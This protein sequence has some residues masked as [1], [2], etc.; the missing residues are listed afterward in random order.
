M[1][2]AMTYEELEA[3]VN[4]LQNQLKEEKEGRNF[5]YEKY[6]EMEEKYNSM[7]ASLQALLSL[8][9]K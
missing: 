1:E 4:Q 9:K 3:K 8:T 6:S 7:R 2:T 5:W